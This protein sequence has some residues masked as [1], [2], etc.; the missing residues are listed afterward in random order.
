VLEVGQRASR[1]LLLTDINSRVPVLI[2]RTRDQAVLAGN[3]TDQP[4]IRYLTRDA[5]IKVGDRIVT[6]GAGGAFP[7]GLPVGEVVGL[8]EGEV[9]VATF[10]DLD[11]L[12]F[13]RLVNYGLS[14]ML[15]DDLGEPG[16]GKGE[17][18][19]G[20]RSGAQRSGE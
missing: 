10:A 12:E 7:P 18:G 3:N 2:E 9:S 15:A 6:S 11:R 14:G 13:V 16:A 4:E 5:D 8:G 17:V 19:A 1:V 20:L